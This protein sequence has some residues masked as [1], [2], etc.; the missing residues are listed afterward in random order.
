MTTLRRSLIGIILTAILLVSVHIHGEAEMRRRLRADQ[1][2][3][4][5]ITYGLF[6]PSEWK[7]IISN[8]LGNKVMDFRLEGANRE[9][10]RRRAIDLMNGL[11]TEA[12]NVMKQRN[13]E[14]GVVGAVKNAAL[15]M[16]I[17]VEA[18][19]T[20]IPRYADMIV[21][22]ANEPS[23]RSEMQCFVMD[24]L[25]EAGK[26]TDGKVDRHL[27][28]LALGRYACTDRSTALRVIETRIAAI[29]QRSRDSYALLALATGTLLVLALTAER[30]SRSGLLGS[31]G[32]GICLLVLGLHLP[33][34]DIEARIERFDLVLLGE[35]ISFTQQTL[36]HQSK[37]ILD[38]VVVLMREGR[39]ELMLVAGLVFAF[40]VVLPTVKLLLSS[41]TLLRRREPRGR[42]ASFLVHRSGKW[43]MADVM[44]VAIFMAYIGFNGVVDSQLSALEEY[45]TSVHVLTMNNS[46]LESG[47][48]LFT[49]YCLIGLI[50]SALLPIALGADAR[51]PDRTGYRE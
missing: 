5:H 39:P 4:S 21:E 37:S 51:Q 24:K 42:L 46:T 47:F 35:P 7:A 48:Y 16:L 29:D 33:M 41:V 22:Y 30:G 20:G 32:A 49:G 8:V 10:V 9:Q 28:E 27:F 17:D 23:T 18:L 26:S 31:I 34:I 12:E 6:D 50:T 36:F 13:K 44:V 38:V 11:L 40:S 15:N 14:K 25:N 19:R 45:A 43:S 3:I 1:M 2:E